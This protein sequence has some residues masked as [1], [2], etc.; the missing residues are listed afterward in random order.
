MLHCESY[1]VIFTYSMLFPQ[2]IKTVKERSHELIEKVLRRS[3][4]VL[5]GLLFVA[6]S[7]HKELLSRI[8]GKLM[9]Y[10]K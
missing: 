8:E 1:D 2:Q 3:N 9:D 7:P 5:D 10:H 6:K 4:V